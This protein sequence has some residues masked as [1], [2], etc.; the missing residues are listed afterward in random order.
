MG[1]TNAY[2]TLYLGVEPYP[3]YPESSSGDVLVMG[4]SRLAL[5]CFLFHLGMLNLQWIKSFD[6]NDE[7]SPLHFLVKRHHSGTLAYSKHGWNALPL[8][9]HYH[10]VVNFSSLNCSIY[11]CTIFLLQRHK[12]CH[13]EPPATTRGRPGHSRSNLP[14]FHPPS[15]NLSAFSRSL[16]QERLLSFHLPSRTARRFPQ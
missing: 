11:I 13:H 6:H 2:S 4:V 15:S 7:W 16:R 9:L 1:I 12:S 8:I 10:R 5:S 14:I 3:L